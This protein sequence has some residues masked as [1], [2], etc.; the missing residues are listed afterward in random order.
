LGRRRLNLQF[1]SWELKCP[2]QLG[3]REMN[4]LVLLLAAVPLAG[5]GITAKIDARQDYQT[6]EAQYKACLS[7][8][9]AAPQNCEGFRLAMEADE[10]KYTN[11]SAGTNPG[12][13]TTRNVTI[14]NR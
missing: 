6:S 4:K 11:L 13:Q 5:C 2:D 14:L 12:S 3:G 7:A 8:N 9:P 10:R 1:A